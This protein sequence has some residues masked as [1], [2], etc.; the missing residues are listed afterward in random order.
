MLT[1]VR[2]LTQTYPT[3]KFVSLQAGRPV[4]KDAGL[5]LPEL[6]DWNTTADIID[7]LDLVISVDTAVAHLAG[8]MN[9]PVWLMNRKASDWRWHLELDTSPWYPS[10]RIFRQEEF[11]DWS[12]VMTNIDKCLGELVNGQG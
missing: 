8:A 1:W 3:I 12:G 11:N 4:P 7:S 2:Q 5:E 6:K 9:K 10:V